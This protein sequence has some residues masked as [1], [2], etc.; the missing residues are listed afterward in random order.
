MQDITISRNHPLF[1]QYPLSGKITI[2][3]GEVPTPYHIYDGHGVLIG[4]TSDLS[5]V[6]NLLDR[7]CVKPLDNGGGRTPMAIW[8]CNFT[9]ASLGPHHE[10]QFSFF[11]GGHLTR[12]QRNHSF[13][14]LALM[15]NPQTKMLCHG[16]WNSTPQVVVYNRELLSLNARLAHS[17]I[18]DRIG[19]VD[20]TFED[21]TT[22]KPII[23]GKFSSCAK[24]SIRATWDAMT[25]IGFSRAWAMAR[26]PW[27]R[28]QIMNPTNVFLSR[29]AVAE[30]FTKNDV[31]ILR[32]Y[33]SLS[34]ELVFGDTRYAS[35]DFRAQF[36][37]CMRGFKFVYLEPH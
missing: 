6:Q 10:L 30:S 5:A 29:N 9:D 23:S 15:A 33:D 2:S 26:Q 35:L 21:D 31:N 32:Y 27:I 34:D 13:Q 22:R 12:R 28:L 7:E 20:F 37:Q 18:N 17:R 3:T 1:R 8:V 4:G 25:Q 19:K 14:L 11:T 36:V 16:L 24:P